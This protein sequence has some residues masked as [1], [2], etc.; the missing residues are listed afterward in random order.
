MSNDI[1]INRTVTKWL[2]YKIKKNSNNSVL[3]P[4]AKVEE[5][6]IALFLFRI[7]V[8]LSCYQRETCIDGDYLLLLFFWGIVAGGKAGQKCDM[9]YKCDGA[10]S[11]HVTL[12]VFQVGKQRALLNNYI[13]SELAYLTT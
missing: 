1:Q 13:N 6:H 7:M 2:L 4:C 12:L 9:A 5:E 8:F 11:C 10:K 3:K